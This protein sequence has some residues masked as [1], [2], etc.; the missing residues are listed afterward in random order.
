MRTIE[1]GMM[2]FWNPERFGARLYYPP[3]FMQ[4][5]GHIKQLLTKTGKKRG[6]T[7]PKCIFVH[8]YYYKDEL[9][10]FLGRKK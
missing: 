3:C 6:P 7:P 1:G 8:G 5:N 9:K 4:N 2:Q 10:V